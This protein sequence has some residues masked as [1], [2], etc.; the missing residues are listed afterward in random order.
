MIAKV[1]M[2]YKTTPN[3]VAINPDL[4]ISTQTSHT[5]RSHS[6]QYQASSTSTDFKFSS[7]PH[8]YSCPLECLTTWYCLCL[9]FGS[10]QITYIY[11]PT[12]TRHFKNTFYFVYM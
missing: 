6:L 8:S 10:V 9:F 4:Y 3:M 11:K 1:T 5:W 12:T 7:F 2:L